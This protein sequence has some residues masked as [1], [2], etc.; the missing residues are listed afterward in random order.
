M[1]FVFIAVLLSVGVFMAGCASQP[2][3]NALIERQELK[4]DPEVIYTMT[5]TEL[6]EERLP[7]PGGESLLQIQFAVEARSDAELAW[8]VTWFDASGLVVKGVGDA[9]RKASVLTGQTRY[10]KAAAPHARA[11]SYQLHLREPK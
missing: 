2:E 4:V 5:V 1:R 3:A 8:K 9:Y 7:Q 11:T 6:L 10:F